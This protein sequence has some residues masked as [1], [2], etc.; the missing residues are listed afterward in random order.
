MSCSIMITIVWALIM[1]HQISPTHSIHREGTCQYN[2]LS[3]PSCDNNNNHNHNNNN[4]C[5]HILHCDHSHK[6]VIAHNDNGCPSAYDQ[7]T[8]VSSKD[9]CRSNL[10]KEDI[11]M[12]PM[13]TSES[14]RVIDDKGSA[15]EVGIDPSSN[16][17]IDVISSSS[18]SCDS[19]DGN[20]P[21]DP[22][23]NSQS[24]NNTA[25]SS[26]SSTV[27]IDTSSDASS[28]SS[29]VDNDHHSYPKALSL[30]SI[31]SKYIDSPPS[32]KKMRTTLL[33]KSS[34]QHHTNTATSN[35]LQANGTDKDSL[36]KQFLAQFL[37]PLASNNRRSIWLD[38]EFALSLKGRF[39]YSFHV[40]MYDM[41][42][43]CTYACTYVCL[44][45][46]MMYA[47]MN[48][49]MICMYV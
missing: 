47:R 19:S 14:N 16:V 18:S 1:I 45:V 4:N 31:W 37:D 5:A 39:N 23:N 2:Y 15:H 42:D 49:C 26:T 3:S 7:L 36:Y 20:G 32:A 40:C 27:V 22:D 25:T 21:S 48:V 43:V 6:S 11:I 13:E 12:L 44:Y 17:I 24:E 41:Y 33:S 34:T 28:S 46:C 10:S 38:Q 35:P 29:D 8:S 30:K 9:A